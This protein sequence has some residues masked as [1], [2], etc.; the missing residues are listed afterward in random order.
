M[1]YNP[2]KDGERRQDGHSVRLS[3]LEQSTIETK[4]SLISV[5]K[6]ITEIQKGVQD[7][8]KQGLAAI[9]GKIDVQQVNCTGH[10]QRTSRLETAHGYIEKALYGLGTAGALIAG[11]IL[12]HTGGK[13]K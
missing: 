7:E 5:H 13:G 1:T 11:W 2:E 9:F 10:L 12:Q 6:R 4:H 3:L 8:I